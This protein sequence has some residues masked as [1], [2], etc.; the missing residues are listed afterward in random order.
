ME[1][2]EIPSGFKTTRRAALFPDR[3]VW[4]VLLGVVCLGIANLQADATNLQGWQATLL[5][6]YFRGT[7]G[8]RWTDGVSPLIVQ[9]RILVRL[10][11]GP[12]VRWFG[13]SPGMANLFW[14]TLF[15][16]AGSLALEDTARRL[17]LSRMAA[18][19]GVFFALLG[20]NWGFLRSGYSIAY[21]YDLPAFAFV[22]LALRSLVLR[23]R[24][25]F[26][27]MLFLGTLNKETLVF[28]IPVYALSRAGGQRPAAWF[29]PLAEAALVFALAYFLPRWLLSEEITGITASSGSPGSPRWQDNLGHLLGRNMVH[30]GQHFLWVALFHLPALLMWKKLPFP[31]KQT[32]M[33]LPLFFLPVFLFG[34]LWEF[35]LFGEILPLAGLATGFWLAG[36]GGESVGANQAGR[37][38]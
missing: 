3:L 32:Y 28:L 26:L 33:C 30:P 36:E 22:C 9:A 2:T 5:E 6:D 24:F 38:S 23:Q 25:L 31:V 35:R 34:N 1:E 19:A 37:V 8:N 13:I 14:Q 10:L 4:L 16:L 27:A 21:P 11:L 20:L 17:G 12:P 7:L 18:R 29:L 15:L